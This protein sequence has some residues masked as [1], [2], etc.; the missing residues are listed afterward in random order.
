MQFL[1]LFN[2]LMFMWFFFKFFEISSPPTHNN[3]DIN[4][5]IQYN[6]LPFVNQNQII[7]N[8]IQAQEA[9]KKIK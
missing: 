1:L 6:Q 2:L 7:L 8:N 4:I 9:K 3:T 5:Y